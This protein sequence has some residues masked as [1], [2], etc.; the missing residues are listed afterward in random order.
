MSSEVFVS[1][2]PDMVVELQPIVERHGR[3]VMD[4]ALYLLR[5]E[6][7]RERR[8]KQQPER[9]ILSRVSMWYMMISIVVSFIP[10]IL[11]MLFDKDVERSVHTAALCLI[12][13]MFGLLALVAFWI[14][15]LDVRVFRKLYPKE[16]EVLWGKIQ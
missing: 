6:I 10:S 16:A 5:M 13:S 7:E 4:H 3:T 2:P 15:Y 12:G 11:F 14:T 9:D 1:I 8:M